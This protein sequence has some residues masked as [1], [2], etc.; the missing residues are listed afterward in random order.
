V[1]EGNLRLLIVCVIPTEVEKSVLNVDAIREILLL[2]FAPLRMTVGGKR[3][4]RNLVARYD[5]LL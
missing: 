5:K 3:S 2:R 1:K 4:G